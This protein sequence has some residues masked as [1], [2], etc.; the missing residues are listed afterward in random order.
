ME[1]YFLGRIWFCVVWD[2]G[3]LHGI[4]QI[5]AYYSMLFLI[6][7]KYLIFAR[8]DAEYAKIPHEGAQSGEY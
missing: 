2:F 8:D 4:I 3:N 7:P 5:L 1:K 6:S